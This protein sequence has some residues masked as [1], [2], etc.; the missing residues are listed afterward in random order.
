MNVMYL[1][2]CIN[3]S[4]QYIGSAV[5]FKKRFSTPKVVS[6]PKNKDAQLLVSSLINAGIYRIIIPS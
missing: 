4:E 1:I 5:D 3:C 2:S 6:T